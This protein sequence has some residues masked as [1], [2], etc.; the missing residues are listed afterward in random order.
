MA[1]AGVVPPSKGGSAA[2]EF[3]HEDWGDEARAASEPVTPRDQ[4]ELP[5]GSLQCARSNRP[6]LL[7]EK[8]FL[9]QSLGAGG[10]REDGMTNL[11]LAASSSSVGLTW[12]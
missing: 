2:A 6:E 11:G 10:Q 12:A 9:R 5:A 8:C 3:R 1:A 7:R 4:G